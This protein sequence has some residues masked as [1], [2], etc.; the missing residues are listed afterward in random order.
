M[1]VEVVA[2]HAEIESVDTTQG[3]VV[4]LELVGGNNNIMAADYIKAG[5]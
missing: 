4:F 1:I 5:Y 2:C 3:I